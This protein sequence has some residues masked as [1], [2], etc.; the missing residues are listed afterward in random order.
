MTQPAENDAGCRDMATPSDRPDN[1]TLA[2]E[3]APITEVRTVET[4]WW[5]NTPRH[6]YGTT[7]AL[8]RR[9]QRIFGGEVEVIRQTIT[10]V[11]TTHVFPPGEGNDGNQG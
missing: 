2:E 9:A 7:E 8:A 6:A 4:W 5:R 10:T 3:D 11:T 1:V